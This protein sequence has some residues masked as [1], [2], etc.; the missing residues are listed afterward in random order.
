M[1]AAQRAAAVSTG[2]RTRW[3]AG[4][5][6]LALGALVG[7][8]GHLRAAPPLPA[9]RIFAPETV[10]VGNVYRGSFTPDG[11]SFYYF[12]QVTEGQEDYRLFRSD[13]TA[14]GWSAPIRVDLGGEHSDLYP[15]ISPDGRRM[16]FASYRP[17]PGDTAAAP[18]A[19]L[20]Y[21]ERVADGWSAPVFMAEAS[22]R[23][24]YDAKPYF[25]PDGGL[26]FESTTPDWET[27]HS[28]V[29]R[30]DGERYPAP[31][32]FEAVERWRGWCAD[33]HVWGGV[34]GPDGRFVVHVSERD[35]ETGRPGPSDQWVSVRGADGRWKEPARLG[36]G[37]N[38]PGYDNFTFF[39]A[40]GTE[41]FFVRDFDRF[42]RIPVA[43]ALASVR[44]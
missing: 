35:A 18:N 25:G 8:T 36:A 21:A 37:L 27:T 14:G 11:R 4:V 22:T 31:A 16:V 10:S 2:L 33:L 40:D 17:L 42:Y 32:P 1:T 24:N 9:P 28:L 3:W 20:W 29:T 6:L 13:R 34:L 7:C 41:L 30:W 19:N 5:G 38:A 43:A 12:K 39:S 26:Y 23:P 15:A 44:E